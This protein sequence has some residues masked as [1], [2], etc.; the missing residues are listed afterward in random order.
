MGRLGIYVHDDC[1]EVHLQTHSIKEAGFF[2]KS[3][4]STSGYC[5]KEDRRATAH[6]GAERH[7]GGH[8]DLSKGNETS[9]GTSGK[10][11]LLLK[12]PER[13]Q[14]EIKNVVTALGA[15]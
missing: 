14:R 12:A 9:G 8:S 6:W 2:A 1:K 10:T 7:R 3:T 5:L 13:G 4:T 15:C 11:A